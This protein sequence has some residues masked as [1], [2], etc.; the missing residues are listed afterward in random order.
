HRVSRR[1]SSTENRGRSISSSAIN[2][3]IPIVEAA[4]DAIGRT[5]WLS[6]LQHRLPLR[7]LPNDLLEAL[8]NGKIEYTKARLLG[9]LTDEALGCEERQAAALRIR[10]LQRTLEES[11]SFAA[12]SQLVE[13]EMAT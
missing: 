12:L 3:L 13:S 11:L 6:F 9:R 10:L 8:R 2:R 4:F 7:R 5:N 1:R